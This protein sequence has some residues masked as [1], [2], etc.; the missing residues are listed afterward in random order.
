VLI[1]C[2]K[3]HALIMWN[4]FSSKR[5]M[6]VINY[7]TGNWLRQSTILVKVTTYAISGVARRSC[8][9]MK[10]FEPQREHGSKIFGGGQDPPGYATVCYSPLW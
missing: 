4:D 10:K 8:H 7:V 2:G 6:C 5:L 9:P 3:E 1:L